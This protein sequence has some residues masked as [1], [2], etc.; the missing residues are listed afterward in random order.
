MLLLILLLL[1]P[2]TTLPVTRPAEA[3]ETGM[4]VY[5]GDSIIFGYD[6]DPGLKVPQHPV[7]RAKLPV[8]DVHC[9]WSSEV[10][11]KDMLAAMDVTNVAYAVNLSGGVGDGVIAMLDL[12]D[13]PRLKILYTLSLENF[14]DV[15]WVERTVADFERAV[16]AGA[17]GMKVWKD[18][19]LTAMD[20]E[21][22]RIAIDDPRLGPLWEKAGEL[23]VPV[24]IHSSDPHAFFDPIDEHNERWMQLHRHPDWS[25]FGPQFPPYRQLLTEHD[26]MIAAHPNTQF[27]GAH[28]AG[29]AEDLALL[30]ERLRKLPNL[31]VDI[32]GRVAE[33]GRQ[34]YTT[35]K[36]LIEFQDRVLYGTDRYPGRPDQPRY[37]IYFRFLETADEYFKYYDHPFPPTG[38]WRIYGVFLP[39]EVLKKIYHE[40]AAK[41]FG[42]D[43]PD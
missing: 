22:K 4:A 24:L 7:P 17:A 19:G 1:A 31:S 29:D 3:P 6:P 33:L 23:D 28:M 9:H 20:G 40:N 37:T 18:L 41:L 15:D 14:D 43:I 34:P 11:Q 38:D 30:A 26:R 2:P 16:N 36:F 27:I 42:L 35:R 10:S 13:S 39:D 25:F 12:Y 8:V 32:S 5:A 21:E